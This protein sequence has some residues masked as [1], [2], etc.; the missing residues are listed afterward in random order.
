MQCVK[1]S[2]WASFEINLLHLRTE[3]ILFDSDGYSREIA[4]TDRRHGEVQGEDINH[5][6]RYVSSNGERGLNWADLSN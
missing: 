2:V 5:R 6:L 3:T 1:T 4:N